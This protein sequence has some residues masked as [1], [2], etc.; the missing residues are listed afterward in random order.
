M[1]QG[2]VSGPTPKKHEGRMALGVATAMPLL[3]AAQVLLTWDKVMAE[4]VSSRPDGQF[5]KDLQHFRRTVQ[6]FADWVDAENAA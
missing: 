5:Q 4:R 3:R 2:V 6:R 1:T